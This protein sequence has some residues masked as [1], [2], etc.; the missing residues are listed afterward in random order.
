MAKVKTMPFQK[1]PKGAKPY[2]PA[3]PPKKG[4]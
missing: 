2:P 1:V 4:K 3:M